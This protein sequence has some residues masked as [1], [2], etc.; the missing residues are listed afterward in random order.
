MIVVVVFRDVI[1]FLYKYIW[2]VSKS[3]C[4]KKNAILP[5]FQV[6]SPE[7]LQENLH[8]RYWVIRTTALVPWV[9]HDY[10]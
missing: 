2:Q 1:E 4:G 9:G 6:L 8:A 5:I 7:K 3:K 10:F